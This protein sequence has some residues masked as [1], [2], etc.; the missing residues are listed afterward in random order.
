MY[1]RAL[2]NM[3]YSI[4][5]KIAALVLLLGQFSGPALGSVVKSA[6]RSPT[7]DIAENTHL[8]AGVMTKYASKYASKQSRVWQCNRLIEVV[9][10]GQ[11]ISQNITGTDAATMEKLARDLLGL[12]QRIG[13]VGL[14]DVRLQGYRNR[15]VRIYNSL[16]TAA[17]QVGGALRALDQIPSTPAGVEQAQRLQQQV[18]QASQIGD[19][20][21]QQ[22]DILVREVN[23]YC[24]G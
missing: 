13:N 15:F 6:G 10:Q 14:R 22:E 4:S 1:L 20:A 23:N 9:N 12:S 21:A 2:H 11:V 16:S 5:F 8:N 18:Q 3:R 24:G 7:P 19:R 17:S